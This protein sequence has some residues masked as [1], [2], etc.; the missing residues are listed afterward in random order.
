M[1]QK[2]INQAF[3]SLPPWAKGTLAV[4]GLAIVGYLGYKLMSIPKNFGENK[5]SRDQNNAELT[6][7]QTLAAQ[8]KKPTLSKAQMSHIANAL[9]TAMDG[10]GTDEDAIIAQFRKM[11]NDLDFLGVSLTYGIREVSSGRFNPEPNFKGN[12]SSALI[13]ELSSYWIKKINEILANAKIKYRI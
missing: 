5:P 13:S 11:K 6:E 7:Q 4:G 10:Y 12:L 3:Q 2:N 8:G 9:F 1:N